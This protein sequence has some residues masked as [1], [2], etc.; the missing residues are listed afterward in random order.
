[1]KGISIRSV[2]GRPVGWQGLAEEQLLQM[3]QMVDHGTPYTRVQAFHPL[4][5]IYTHFHSIPHR[6]K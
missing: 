3:W 2:E 6:Q 1:M 5:G 4:H